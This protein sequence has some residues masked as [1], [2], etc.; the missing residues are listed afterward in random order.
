MI[1]LDEHEYEAAI[2]D[3]KEASAIDDRNLKV[4]NS[5]LRLDECSSAVGLSVQIQMTLAEAYLTSEQFEPCE[6]ICTYLSKT[7]PN[8]NSVQLVRNFARPFP[9]PVLLPI[10]S[11]II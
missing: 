10:P 2:K 7:F 3:L 8:D 4:R 1:Y 6:Q 9:P 5:E 11:D